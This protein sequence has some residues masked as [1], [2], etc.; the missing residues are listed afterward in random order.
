MSRPSKPG[1]ELDNL[2]EQKNLKDFKH[3]ATIQVL[4]VV[5]LGSVWLGLLALDQPQLA[6]VF[7][8]V[9]TAFFAKFLVERSQ[10]RPT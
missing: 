3:V 8:C 7:L 5:S 4:F 6:A 10:N 9:G 2:R 1:E